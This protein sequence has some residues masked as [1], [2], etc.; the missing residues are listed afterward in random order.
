MWTP[1]LICLEVILIL[2]LVLQYMLFT[3]DISSMR[4]V[5]LI[6]LL[7]TLNA[8]VWDTVILN[9]LMN[10]KT[11]APEHK[12]IWVECSL[13]LVFI[14]YRGFTHFSH[15]KYAQIPYISSILNL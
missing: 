10:S 6:L 15:R 9:E 4:L 2:L 11:N 5:Q 12:I 1:T 8:K 14:F 13:G 3:I 7:V